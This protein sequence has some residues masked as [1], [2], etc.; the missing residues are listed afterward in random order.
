MAERICTFRGSRTATPLAVVMCCYLCVFADAGDLPST[1]SPPPHSLPD[2]A[3]NLYEGYLIVVDGQ[4]GN[5]QHQNLLVDTGTNPSM[6]DRRIAATLGLH[7][8]SRGLAL[9]NKRLTA[10]S[11]TLPELQMGPL[12]RRNLHVMVADFSKIGKG[13]GTHIDAVIGLDVLGA[14]SFTIDYQK[15]RIYFHASVERNSAS[16]TTTQQ[17]I[18]VNFKTGNRQLRLLLDTGTPHLVLFKSA[19][20][21]LDYDWTALTGGGQNLSGAVYYGTVILPQARLGTTDIGPLRAAVVASQRDV[22]TDYDGL[23]PASLL[24][25]KRLS[26]DFDRQLLAWSN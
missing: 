15:R 23:I 2:I 16:F 5:L 6:I 12:R 18:S 1:V 7:G 9:F 8:E 24:R 3:F 20:H 25:P 17:L 21:H 11:V 14:T 13:L 22:E 4:I 26:F 19:L 10:E